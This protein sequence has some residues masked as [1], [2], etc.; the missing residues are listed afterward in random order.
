VTNT[1]KKGVKRSGTKLRNIGR[2]VKCLHGVTWRGE[3]SKSGLKSVTW[4]MERP[5]K[6]TSPL[7]RGKKKEWPPSICEARSARF[8]PIRCIRH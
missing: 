4:F 1:I 5:F 8:S 6:L 3:G 2:G 7:E